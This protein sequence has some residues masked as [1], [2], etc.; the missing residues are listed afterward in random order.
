M[1][2][3]LII[4]KNKKLKRKE[5]KQKSITKMLKIEDKE[6]MHPSVHT[7]AFSWKATQV[8]NISLL[9]PVTYTHSL[10]SSSATFSTTDRFSVS[11]FKTVFLG[12]WILTWHSPFCVS[13]LCKLTLIVFFKRPWLSRHEE[14]N[15]WETNLLLDLAS[16]YFNESEK[17][18][19]RVENTISVC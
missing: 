17:A 14:N 6:N 8:L 7:E 9:F 4:H 16:I 1:F 2:Y 19:K 15:C 3:I 12:G 18:G 5:G 11:V 13:L 10:P